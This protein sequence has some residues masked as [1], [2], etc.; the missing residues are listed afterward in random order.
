[1]IRMMFVVMMILCST[2]LA[3]DDLHLS[4]W[5]GKGGYKSP[6]GLSCCGVDDCPVVYGVTPVSLP[7]PGFRLATGEFVPLSESLPS[8]DQNY[9]RCHHPNGQRRCFFFPLPKSASW[10]GWWR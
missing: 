9:Y 5:I 4:D 1:M 8:E 3:H 10:F 6:G 2:A 7:A